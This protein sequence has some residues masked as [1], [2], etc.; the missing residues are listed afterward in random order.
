MSSDTLSDS[1]RR[2][3][4]WLQIVILV[5]IVSTFISG[6]ATTLIVYD[7]AQKRSESI[8]EITGETQGL[9]RCLMEQLVLHR[10]DTRGTHE[11]M[12]REH[13][14]LNPEFEDRSIEGLPPPPRDI[15]VPREDIEEDLT[16]ACNRYLE[17]ND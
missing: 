8:E 9:G 11:A 3:P 1:M 17:L 16:D 14:Q 7:Q 15:P 5:F 10:H 4:V 12:S 6:W 13:F 2:I